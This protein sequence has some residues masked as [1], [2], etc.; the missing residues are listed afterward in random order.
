MTSQPL[1]G[2]IELNHF[3]NLFILREQRTERCCSM[4]PEIMQ[5][6]QPSARSSINRNATVLL[7]NG[8][9]KVFML[10]SRAT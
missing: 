5:Q 4:R 3:V 7:K 10:R 2:F 9:I 8:K 1:P 6:Q